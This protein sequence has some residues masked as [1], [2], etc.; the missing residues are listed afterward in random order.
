MTLYY[1]TAV[2]LA[3][4]GLLGSLAGLIGSFAVLRKRSLTGDALAHAA[5]PGVCIAYLLIGQRS[6]PILLLGALVSGVLGILTINLLTSRTRIREDAAIG[7]VLGVFFGV[8]IALSTRIQQLPGG[9]SRAGLDS[10][11]FGKAA[12]MTFNDVVGISVTAAICLVIVLLLY[13]QFKLISFDAEFGQTLGWPVR[14]LDLALMSLL[15][16]TVVIGLPA[17]GVVLTAAMVIIPGASARFWTD[18]FGN[19]LGLSTLFGLTMGLLGTL[20]SAFNRSLPTG[21]TIVLCGAAIFIISL[22]CG[23]RRGV[24]ARYWQWR[25]FETEISR[26]RLLE[27]V[28]ELSQRSQ[29]RSLPVRMDDLLQAQVWQRQ[30]LSDAVT[31]AISHGE[32]SSSSRGFELT[33]AG[34][35]EAI[36]VTRTHLLWRELLQEHPEQASAITDLTAPLAEQVQP[37]L[38]HKMEHSLRSRGAWPELPEARP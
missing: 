29:A 5:L 15:A 9:G 27:G 8:G 4:I 10:F 7:S 14:W 22:L 6:L 3:G 33:T 2:V 34:A 12:S 23:Y 38:I 19:M 17:V 25:R 28:W 37:E 26:R 16:V 35:A 18:R 13:K 24:I 20:F 1:N 30:R 36:E 11:L 32:I 21:P 31:R